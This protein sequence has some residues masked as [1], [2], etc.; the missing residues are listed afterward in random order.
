MVPL[1]LAT[2][3]SFA[4]LAEDEEQAPVPPRPASQ[5]ASSEVAPPIVRWTEVIAALYAKRSIDTTLGMDSGNAAG[6]VFSDHHATTS[7]RD[8]PTYAC[9]RVIENRPEVGKPNLPK[10]LEYLLSFSGQWKDCNTVYLF[11]DNRPLDG[12][13]QPPY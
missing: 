1:N 7:V 5:L 8:P 3:N 6:W 4:P 9:K 13:A 11:V 10:L 12:H 2:S